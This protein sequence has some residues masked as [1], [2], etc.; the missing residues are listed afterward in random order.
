MVVISVVVGEKEGTPKHVHL[1]ASLYTESEK[2]LSSYLF[3]PIGK[4]SEISDF[5][6]ALSAHGSRIKAVACNQYGLHCM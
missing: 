6:G 3:R 5:S 1:R 2:V 4:S